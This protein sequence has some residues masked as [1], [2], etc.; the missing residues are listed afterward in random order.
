[1]YSDARARRVYAGADAMLVPS[2]FEP[3]GLTQMM[4]FRYGALPIVR[5]TG[6]LKDTV[7]PYNESDG[8]GTGFSFTEYS[9]EALLDTINYAKRIYFTQREAWNRL[10]VNGMGLDFSWEKSAAQYKA[11]YVDMTGPDEEPVA[12][13][14]PVSVQPEA[15]QVEAAQ[16]E[17]VVEAEPAK[18]EAEVEAAA[19]PA[20]V[21]EPVA[22]PVKVEA[23]VET[24]VDAVAEPAK[25]EVEAEPAKEEA[26]PAEEKAEAAKPAKKA[27]KKTPA[28]K[29][30][31]SA[32]KKKSKS[33][34]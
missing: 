17:A 6:G 25:A 18:V 27:A 28:K 24:A 12:E 15:E 13:A 11:L 30:T 31:A 8:T 29:A 5:A 32:A 7:W 22:E 1:M 26:A 2:R 19:E 21:E 34:K 3:C 14:A 20:K 9:G 4:A 10:V 23:E 16:P 33:T